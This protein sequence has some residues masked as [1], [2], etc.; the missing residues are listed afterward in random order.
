[1]DETKKVVLIGLPETGK[2]TFLAALWYLVDGKNNTAL[3]L[4]QLDGDRTYLNKIRDK[5]LTFE[6][7]DHTRVD[8]INLIS[9]RLLTK[10]LKQ[11]LTIN[12]PDLSGETFSTQ[13]NTRSWSN[14]YEMFLTQSIGSL[15]FINPNR[16][17]EPHRIQ[18]AQLLVSA[19]EEN[20]DDSTERTNTEIYE[21][22]PD[23]SPTQVKL[24]ELLQFIQSANVTQNPYKLVLIISAWDDVHTSQ[25]NPVKWLE[26]R[27]PLLHQYLSSN[28]DIF[29]HKIFGISAQG[30]DYKKA[31]NQLMEKTDPADRIN[32]VGEEYNGSDLTIPLTWLLE[33]KN[34]Q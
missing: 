8:T 4:D 22:D 10:D 18:D 13:W 34:D 24:V 7:V 26:K 25:K 21:W 20:F 1:M 23:S 6:E 19:L 9:L 31:D 28:Q 30:A 32:I 17:E 11:T 29:E 33:N 15:L 2:T 27:L 16:I 12:I 3:T 14:E 5:W